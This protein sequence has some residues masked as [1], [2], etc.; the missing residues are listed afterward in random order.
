M[1]EIV[2]GY[3]VMAVL[4]SFAHYTAVR[5]VLCVNCCQC[6]CD[7]ADVDVGRL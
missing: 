7:L 6:V 2:D 4:L 5:S 1:I 3:V